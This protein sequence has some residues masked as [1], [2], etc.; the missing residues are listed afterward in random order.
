MPCLPGFFPVMNEV[1]AGGV[2]GGTIDAS[3]PH[4]P[5]F[6]R[7]ARFGN[8][9]SAIQGMIRSKVAASKPTIK[10]FGFLI[11]FYRGR[12]GNSRQSARQIN[13]A[14][15]SDGTFAR[16]HPACPARCEGYSQAIS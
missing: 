9:P 8:F 7:A 12:G 2:I 1:Q 11:L 16:L 6:I 15:R 5:S 3:L 13:F 4:A 10:T 14:P